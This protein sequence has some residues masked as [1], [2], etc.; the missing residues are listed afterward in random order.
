MK[1]SHILLLLIALL[2]SAFLLLS[3]L[4]LDIQV[5]AYQNDPEAYVLNMCIPRSAHQVTRLGEC[6]ASFQIGR[7]TYII[8]VYKPGHGSNLSQL[9][10]TAQ[11]DQTDR[12]D[13]SRR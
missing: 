5:K 13:V 4:L 2:L 9:G 7:D 11:T 10:G 6:K 8:E 12:T 3:R 1:T